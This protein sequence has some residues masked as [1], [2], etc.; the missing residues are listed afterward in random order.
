MAPMDTGLSNPSGARWRYSPT[1]VA[2]AAAPTREWK[3]ATVCGSSC[4]PTLP[5]MPRPT[6]LPTA[7]MAPTLARPAAVAPA[8]TCLATVAASPRLTP[9]TPRVL[10]MR[11]VSCLPRPATAAMQHAPEASATTPAPPVLPAACS[12]A[13]PASMSATGTP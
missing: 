8:A 3:A 13:R 10:P 9:A 1:A 12:A 11:A 4:G 5:A 6:A 2:M 7:V